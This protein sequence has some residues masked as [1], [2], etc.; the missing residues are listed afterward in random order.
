[1]FVLTKFGKPGRH[2]EVFTRFT[3][4]GQHK[5]KFWGYGYNDLCYNT[6]YI[7]IFYYQRAPTIKVSRIP[8]N[9]QNLQGNDNNYIFSAIVPHGRKKDTLILAGIKSQ[10][11]LFK[12]LRQSF[13]DFAQSLPLGLC[14]QIFSSPQNTS[15]CR[16]ITISYSAIDSCARCI[17]NTWQQ[18]CWSGLLSILINERSTRRDRFRFQCRGDISSGKWVEHISKGLSSGFPTSK[19]SKNLKTIPIKA[20]IP[21][22][23]YKGYF[24]HISLST[25][26]KIDAGSYETL[27][28]RMS[29]SGGRQHWC[30]CDKSCTF[31][32]EK[33]IKAHTRIWLVTYISSSWTNTAILEEL[34]STSEDWARSDS[35]CSKGPGTTTS[36]SWKQTRKEI[37]SVMAAR[38]MDSLTQKKF[39][40]SGMFRQKMWTRGREGK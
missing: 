3:K 21:T 26:Y 8:N 14:Q 36:A 25:T 18:F 15:E 38:C 39:A 17:S 7:I 31:R 6:H 20:R 29:L 35:V 13:I 23:M 1:M 34:L 27:E 24:L 4:F 11:A 32:W 30:A 40:L 33:D 9:I 12:N 2:P 16:R 28:T 22:Q 10:E 19:L 5:H 37:L